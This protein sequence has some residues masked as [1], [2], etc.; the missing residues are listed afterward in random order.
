MGLAVP[1]VKIAAS[2]TKIIT[3]GKETFDTIVTRLKTEVPKNYIPYT[4]PIHKV[5]TDSIAKDL[6]KL[7]VYQG[8]GVARGV[9][10]LASSFVPFGSS[11]GFLTAHGSAGI[12]LI[13]LVI[14]FRDANKIKSYKGKEAAKI[15]DIKFKKLP[16]LSIAV[17]NEMKKEDLLGL[18]NISETQSKISTQLRALKLG[19]KKRNVLS[20]LLY[21]VLYAELKNSASYLDEH[22]PYHVSLKK[23][24]TSMKEV[25]INFLTGETEGLAEEIGGDP[26]SLILESMGLK[27]AS[28]I[29]E[30]KENE[31]EDEEKGESDKP[32]KNKK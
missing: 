9:I 11:V 28:G 7:G 26:I 24:K 25:L 8:S 3:E 1:G 14:H 13:I 20:D 10:D 16:A 19:K 22:Y 6:T 32:K 27:D 2:I 31:K 15:R 30:D 17:V 23:R 29:G 4:S 21:E 12:K 5:L 18:S